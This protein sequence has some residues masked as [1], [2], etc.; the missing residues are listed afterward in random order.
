MWGFLVFLSGKGYENWEGDINVPTMPGAKLG[1]MV[2]LALYEALTAGTPI[3]LTDPVDPPLGLASWEGIAI[4]AFQDGSLKRVANQSGLRNTPLVAA[5]PTKVVGLTTA[6]ARVQNASLG[7]LVQVLA[8]QCR[9]EVPCHQM[10][11]LNP[12]L[13]AVGQLPFQPLYHWFRLS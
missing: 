11:P 6:V 2:S 7:C 8:K 12:S 1:P 5:A 9:G 13:H 10:R 4:P 3:V